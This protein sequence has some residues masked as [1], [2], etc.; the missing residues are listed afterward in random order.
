MF[1]KHGNMYDGLD[2]HEHL[3]ALK[4]PCRNNFSPPANSRIQLLKQEKAVQKKEEEIE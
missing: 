2:L 4:Q 1:D 3:I